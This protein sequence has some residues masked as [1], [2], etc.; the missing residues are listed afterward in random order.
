MDLKLTNFIKVNINNYKKLITSSVSSYDTAV[1]IYY[2]STMSETDPFIQTLANPTT[3]ISGDSVSGLTN[4]AD[5]ITAFFN[6]SGRFL[7]V[8]KTKTLASS[9]DLIS[10]LENV[11]TN[12]KIVGFVCNQSGTVISESTFRG[13]ASAYNSNFAEEKLYQKIFVAEVAY[14]TGTTADLPASVNIENYVLKYG[15]LGISASI[16]AYFTNMSIF[17]TNSVQDYAFTQENYINDSVNSKYYYFNNNDLVTTAMD[18]NINIDSYIAGSVRNLGGN[19]TAGYDLTNQ[20]MLLVLHE[21]LTNS[22]M[23]LIASKIK[24]NQY[25][26]AAVSAV[27]NS[28][29]NKFVSNGYLNPGEEWVD[30]DLYYKGIKIVSKNEILYSGYKVQILPFS[31]L[32]SEEK[33]SHQLPDLYVLIADSYGIRKIVVSGSVF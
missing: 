2:D 1:L 23:S 8:I 18:R 4:I 17:T 28:V 15:S 3:T 11:P 19:D 25:G 16:L 31:T 7:Q 5:Y 10:L 29:L 33:E 6:N 24:Y 32:T 27:A 9:A 20:F 13:Y 21:E 30:N 22:L 14:S 26:S 12:Y